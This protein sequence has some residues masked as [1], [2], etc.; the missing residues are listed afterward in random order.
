MYR[1]SHRDG[2]TSEIKVIMETSWSMGEFAKGHGILLV[3]LQDFTKF[4][5][6]NISPESQ[7]FLPYPSK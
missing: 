7:H 4:W 6:H 3:F 5:K 1:G 2:K